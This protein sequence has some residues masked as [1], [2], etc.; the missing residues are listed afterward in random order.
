M[1]LIGCT[2]LKSLPKNLHKLECL[3]TLSCVGCSRMKS[4]PEIK[5]KMGR[6]RKLNLSKTS[7]MELPSSIRHLHGL[8]ELDLSYCENL[9]RLLDNICSLS[10]LKILLLEGCSKLRGFP[11]IKGDM[12]IFE[13]LDLSETTIEKLPPS[14]GHLKAL[15]HLDLSGCKNLESLPMSICNLSSLQTLLLGGCSK[16]KGF[17]EIKDDMENL[18]RLDLS[19][20]A[21]KELPSSIEHLKALKHLDL[22]DCENLESLPVSICNLNSLQ[23]LL[24]DGCSKLKAILEVNL[25]VDLCSLRSLNLTCCI[26]KSRVIWNNYWFSSLK[27]LNPQCDQREEEILNHICPLSSLV[28]LSVRNSNLMKREVLSDS[29]HLS[30]LQIL[31]P[32]NFHLMKGGILG[33]IFHLSSLV[34]LSL[35]NCK[36]MEDRIPGDIWNLPSLLKLSLSNC[37]LTEG[38]ILNHICHLSSLE[39]LYLDQNHFR[40]IPAG[41]SQLS[42][43]KGLSLSHCKNLLQILELP[44]SL[45]FLDAH[46]SH[47]ISSSPSFLPIHSMVNC[48]K[49]ELIQV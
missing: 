4:F 37:N 12:K 26:L 15:K 30:S 35:R 3:Q 48:F 39:E 24:S 34:N 43:L 31:S 18:E 41:I 7:I 13:R 16:L 5:G 10:S 2:R 49:S 20:T 28:E 27:T 1:N 22:S 38:E 25:G 46:C 11:E 44:T 32:R 42:N 40:S 45:R 8:E 19:E 9:V 36:L 21:I 14:I 29:F 23:T 47:G 17:P 33:D 6:L